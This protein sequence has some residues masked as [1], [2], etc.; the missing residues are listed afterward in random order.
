MEITQEKIVEY[1]KV[2]HLPISSKS[3]DDVDKYMVDFFLEHKLMSE[4]TKD[5]LTI[6]NEG[7]A[8][9]RNSYNFNPVPLTTFDWII[10]II[11]QLKNGQA[12]IK[13][14]GKLYKIA[15]DQL[16]RDGVID[17][18]GM[19]LR[20][21]LTSKGREYVLSGLTYDGWILNRSK[22]NV[23]FGHNFNVGGNINIDHSDLSIE[24]LHR[25]NAPPINTQ[26][27]PIKR[28]S[29]LNFIVSNIWKILIGIFIGLAIIYI[30]KSYLN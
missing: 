16:K 29:I 4:A 6:T 12:I 5:V 28:K 3:H 23:Q 9:I 15:I 17:Q 20:D 8:F 18:V 14:D 13:G 24:A 26:T 22:T 30:A 7:S 21:T 11:D 1:L 19:S 27:K 10:N 2:G 25:S